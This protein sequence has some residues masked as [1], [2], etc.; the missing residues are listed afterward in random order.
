MRNVSLAEVARLQIGKRERPRPTKEACVQVKAGKHE[1]RVG[2]IFEDDM[3]SWACYT[4][5]LYTSP[6]PRDS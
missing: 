4:C 6:S 5:L 2:E 1:N 3:N